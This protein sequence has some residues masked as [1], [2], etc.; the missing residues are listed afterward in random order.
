MLLTGLI[1]GA[2]TLGASE[3]LLGNPG[4]EDLVADAPARWECFTAPQEGAFG[5]LD[6]TAFTGAYSVMLHTPMPYPKEPCNNWNQNVIAKLSGKKLA[7]SGYIKTKD[8][9]EAA[10]WV[11]CWRKN[12]WGVLYVANSSHDTPMYGTKDWQRIDLAFDVP[13]ETDFVTVRCVIKGTGTVWF[14]DLSLVETGEAESGEPEAPM[15]PM[16]GPAPSSTASAGTSQTKLDKVEDEV[17]RL[18]N[19]NMALAEA[20]DQMQASNQQL[21]QELTAIRKQ[22]KRLQESSGQPKAI[23]PAPADSST[24]PK[25]EAPPLVPHGEDWRK[26]I[27]CK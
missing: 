14:D 8:V 24:P 13:K 4:F 17:T 26:L 10:I 20:L 1:L 7:V 16:G 12:P 23:E 27:E 9:T 19:A 5:R 22:L 25:K 11:Q 3:N 18:R 21:M 2:I 6:N 15:P